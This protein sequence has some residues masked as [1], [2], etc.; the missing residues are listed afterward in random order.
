M[1]FWKQRAS[2]HSDGFIV[3]DYHVLTLQL[4]DSQCLVWDL[5]TTLP[6]PCSLTDYTKTALRPLTVAHTV[7]ERLYRVVKADDYLQFFASDRTH[8][9][10]QD[11]SWQASP[12]SYPC[13]VASDGTQMR[14]Q[15][16]ISMT[17]PASGDETPTVPYL[18]T[19]YSEIAF[20]QTFLP[21][22][23]VSDTHQHGQLTA[24]ATHS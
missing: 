17:S 15:Q 8:M 2:Q 10:G 22:A 6:F 16:Y 23:L 18:G 7:Y 21:T 9:R 12:P 4:S 5:D 19:V 13:I 1:P 20:L 24:L 11:G 14:L 3:W